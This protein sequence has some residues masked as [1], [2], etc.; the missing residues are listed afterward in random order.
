MSYY[1]DKYLS[2]VG[3]LTLVGEDDYL[4][5]L[6]IEGQTIFSKYM[7]KLSFEENKDI[8]TLN[9]VK[10]WL[11]DYFSFKQPNSRLIKLKLNGSEFQKRVWNLLLDIPYGEVRTYKELS[12]IIAK[13][14]NLKKMSSQAIGQAV[15]HNP[16][17]IIIPCHRVVGSNNKLTGYNGGI[18]KKIKLLNIENVDLT[19]FK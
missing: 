18:D 4:I 2:P 6:F 7:N 15:G 8:S 12:E 19:N 13:E 10:K 5:G 11:D 16:I 17:S 1:I 3:E 9:K 14:R